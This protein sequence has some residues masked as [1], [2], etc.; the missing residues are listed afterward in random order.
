MRKTNVIVVG[1]GSIG[2]RHVRC[3]LRTAECDVS[4]CE[5]DPVKRDKIAGLY[6]LQR[7]FSEFDNIPLNDFQAVVIATPTPL[8]ISQ[9]LAAAKANCHVLCEKP[10]S[11]KLD[12]IQE[13]ID[14]LNAT[15]RV[16]ATAFNLRSTSAMFRMKELIHQGAIGSPRFS[17]ANISQYFP[18]IR[19]DYQKIYFAKKSMGGG[20]LFDM[21]P[22]P[23]NLMEW[24]LGPEVEVSAIVERLALKGIETDDTAILNFRYHSGALSQINCTMLAYEYKNKLSVH[25]STGSIV[26]DFVKGTLALYK[27]PEAKS[28]P[29][30][31]KFA[32]GRDDSYVEQAKHF[33]AAIRSEKAVACTLEEGRQTLRAIFAAQKAA[34]TRMS[35]DIIFKDGTSKSI[36]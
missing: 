6:S 17:V 26:Y 3:F 22:H 23:T 12:S 15:K 1:G 8:H 5:T 13:L 35:Q 31:E 33:L 32:V 27:Q 20:T 28:Q 18:V 14:T 16:G 30:I 19:P 10:L 2:E 9:S 29:E 36:I 24:F 21:C 7:T 4:L 25:G 34:K 11:D